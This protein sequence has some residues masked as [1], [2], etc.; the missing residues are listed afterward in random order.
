MVEIKKENADGT[1][2]KIIPTLRGVG[3]IDASKKIQIDRYSR[4]SDKGVSI[5]FLDTLNTFEGWKT[6]LDTKDAWIQYNGID[7]G[8]VN[9]KSVKLRVLSKTG[10]TL[11][12]HLDKVDSPMIAQV[13]IPKSDE[14]KIAN[15]PLSE[16]HLGIHNLIV[17]LKD[18]K[19]VEVDWVSF[20]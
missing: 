10:G 3:L 14:W 12:I 19:N 17:L 9:F 6:V 16:Y 1:I 4:K 13:E 15:S 18:N 5:A 8:K 11:Q 7:F 20:E 2:R